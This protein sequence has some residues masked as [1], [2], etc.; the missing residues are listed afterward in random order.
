[1]LLLI[2]LLALLTVLAL[3]AVATYEYFRFRGD[4]FVTCPETKTRVAVK[5]DAAHSAVSAAIGNPQLRLCECTRWPEKKDCGQECLRQIETAP[6][7]C[8]VR[9][10]VS[11]WYDDKRCTVCQRAIGPVHW[12]D[13]PPALVDDEGHTV[14]W[15]DVPLARLPDFLES[16]QPVCWNC[17]IVQTF[18]REHP[19][20]IV[21]RKER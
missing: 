18:R 19:E 5:V 1:M 16:H 7:D 14:E 10:V 2:G 4:R 21:E 11:R 6:A 13:H 8:L 15:K 17:H 20:L 12:H 9:N 3:A